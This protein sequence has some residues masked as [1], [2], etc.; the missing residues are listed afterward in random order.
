[1]NLNDLTK[2]FNFVATTFTDKDDG[3]MTHEQVIAFLQT[4]DNL[5][6]KLVANGV[7]SKYML[8]GTPRYKRSE[9]VE[10]MNFK[11]LII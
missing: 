5:L 8:Y 11:K 4:N 1:M 7:I 10:F 9:V 6:S 3:Y 2:F